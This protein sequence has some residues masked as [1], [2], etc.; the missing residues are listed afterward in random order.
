MRVPRQTVR[1]LT[2]KR[3]APHRSESPIRPSQ[4]RCEDAYA[5]LGFVCQNIGACYSVC[6]QPGPREGCL[7]CLQQL[8][9]ACRV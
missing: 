1:N 6:A 8:A 3:H 2:P 7:G 4:I 9:G 5:R